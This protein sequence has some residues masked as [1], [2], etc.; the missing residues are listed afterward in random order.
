MKL[1]TIALAAT[2]SLGLTACDAYAAGHGAP[3][4]IADSSAGEI[5]TNSDG[6]SLYVFDADGDMSSNCDGGCA[7][8]WPPHMAGDGAHEAGDFAPITRS[9]GSMQWAYK[10]RPLYTW[11][12][13]AEVGDVTGDGVGGNWHLARP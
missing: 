5:L 2:L 13:D 10:G 6:M 11:V 3:A 12:G 7:A 9:D 4:I 1:A 8:S